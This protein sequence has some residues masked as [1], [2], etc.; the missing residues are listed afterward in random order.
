MYFEAVKLLLSRF[1]DWENCDMYNYISNSSDWGNCLT[2]AAAT[3][4]LAQPGRHL[5]EKKKK[6]KILCLE[7]AYSFLW[8]GPKDSFSIMSRIPSGPGFRHEV[9]TMDY[10]VPYQPRNRYYDFVKNQKVKVLWSIFV[11]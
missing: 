4:I 1:S 10:L 11:C 5:P 7:M 3:H 8:P 2:D 6:K 9:L